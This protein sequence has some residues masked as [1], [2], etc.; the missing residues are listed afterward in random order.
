MYLGMT[1]TL[2][3]LA[4]LSGSVAALASPLVFALIMQVKFIP[5]EERAL[6]RVFGEQYAAYRARVRAW[7]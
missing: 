5:L 3:G 6:E 4:I 7:L 1:L 2:L